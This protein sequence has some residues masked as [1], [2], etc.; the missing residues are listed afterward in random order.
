MLN[1]KMIGYESQDTKPGDCLCTAVFHYKKQLYIFSH[2]GPNSSR[3]GGR[4]VYL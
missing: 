3:T 2:T 1:K 4:L